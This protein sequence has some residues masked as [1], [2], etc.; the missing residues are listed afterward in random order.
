[1]TTNEALKYGLAEKCGRPGKER[2]AKQRGSG[3]QRARSKA[4]AGTA[5]PYGRQ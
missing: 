2:P 3:R 4:F 1:M 5:A